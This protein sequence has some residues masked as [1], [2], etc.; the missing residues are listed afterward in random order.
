MDKVIA[1][2]V[3]YQP[4]VEQLLRLLNVIS[5]Q[6]EEVLV[7]DNNSTTNVGHW[8]THTVGLSNVYCLSLSDNVGVAKAQNKGIAWARE[9]GAEYVLLL[10]QDSEP[11]FDM[12]GELLAAM[13][14]KQ[15]EGYNTA[16]VGANYADIKGQQVPPFVKLTGF[17]LHRIK[18]NANE[19]VAVD[20]LIASGCLISMAAL[21]KIGVMEEQLFI[22]YVDTEWCLRAIH[23]GYCI[24]GVGS[25]QMRHSLGDSFVHLFGRTIPVHSPLRYYYLVRNG[26]WLLRQP[27]ISNSWRLM[28]IKRLFLIYMAYSLFIDPRY[29]N[30]KMMTLG[31]WHGLRGKTGKLTID[32]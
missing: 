12:V 14:Q 31:I 29:K 15:N 32:V 30:W 19:I 3:T 6:T 24:F 2:V 16:A 26:L 7:V 17:R 27:W 25:A 10:D 28:D 4:N 18:C 23:S 20:H 9:Q 5:M 22:D 21:A 8:L 13:K 11:A 1:V